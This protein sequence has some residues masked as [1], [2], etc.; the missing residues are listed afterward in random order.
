MIDLLA[1]TLLATPLS[2]ENIVIRHD[3]TEAQ[4]INLASGYPTVCSVLGQA[5]ASGTLIGDR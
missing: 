4:S 3:R 5:R 1:V 2:S